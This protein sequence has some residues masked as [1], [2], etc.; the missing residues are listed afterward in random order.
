MSYPARPRLV[1]VALDLLFPQPCSG[2]GGELPVGEGDFPLCGCCRRLLHG[3]LRD[4]SGYCFRCGG[5]VVPEQETPCLRCRDRELAFASHEALFDYRGLLRELLHAFKFSSRTGL[6][7]LF[8]EL[9]ARRVGSAY[10]GS[11]VVPV[12]A[13][14]QRIRSHGYD[15]VDLVARRL[16]TIHHLPVARL[17]HRRGGRQQK[18]LG[19]AARSE[20][21]SGRFR[22]R[23]HPPHRPLL[24]IDDVYTTGATAHECASVLISGGAPAVQVLT[25]AQD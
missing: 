25:L 15:T 21:M 22:L 11:V 19:R 14:L 4:A 20:N 6:G 9:L 5:S 3:E 8:A 12:P 10:R 18:G 16:A 1:T 17:L 7:R 24:L 2:C 23:Q 13:R